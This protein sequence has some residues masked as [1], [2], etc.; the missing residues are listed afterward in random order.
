MMDKTIAK[1]LTL[2]RR[3]QS[4][5]EASATELPEDFVEWQRSCRRGMFNRIAEGKRPTRFSAHLPVVVT[6]KTEGDF[7]AH[8]ATKGTGFTP[9]DEYLD[10][11]IS[12]FDN[13]LTRC[14]GRPWRETLGERVAVA[15]EFYENSDHIDPR[16][17][18]LLEI[19]QG[20]TYRNLL[21]D[22]H[23][24]LHYTGEGPD[25]PSFQINGLAEIV[26]PEDKRFQFI[27]LARQLFEHDHF[28]IH[29]P[30]YPFGYVV[31]VKEAYDKSPFHGRAGMQINTSPRRVPSFGV[32]EI[33]IPVD[34]SRYAEYCMKIGLQL[35]DHFSATMTGIHVYA[36]RLHD[37]RF[38]QMEAGL[39]PQYQEPGELKRQR[40]IHDSLITQGLELISD[41]YLNVLAER[42]QSAQIDFIGKR[43]EGKN[44]AALISEIN[45]GDYDLVLLGARGLGETHSMEWAPPPLGSVTERVARRSNADLLVVKNASPIGGKIVVAVDGSS[46]SFAGIRLALVLA[47]ATGATVEA[48]AAY[49]PHF[50]TVA[51][52]EL[53]GVLSPE[54]GRI[55]RFKEQE[56][57]H[58]EIID[59][60]IAKI[61]SDHLETAVRIAEET[62]AEIETTLLEGKPYPAILTYLEDT[63]PSL[64][65][66]GRLGV[67][68]DEHLDLGATAENLLRLAPCHVLLVARKFDPNMTE[69]PLEALT[70]EIPWTTE[71]LKRLENIPPFAR[72]FARKAIDDFARKND[73]PEVTPDVMAVAREELGM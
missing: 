49:D 14:Q 48:V 51:F 63:Q 59:Q 67:H 5:F 62:G 31:W 53:E 37:D 39:P 57:L 54:A 7:L 45:A 28:H 17:L 25:Y 43:P 34:N 35:A 30:D 56:K 16:R 20:Q 2:D 70:E 15:R 13:C 4:G 24:T 6:L 72:S 10:D 32:K 60:G 36:A 55:F 18:G 69:R 61:Y 50:H 8:S 3:S 52:R 68:A 44:Y 73:H 21:A 26:G 19:F 46:Q 9:R 38:K 47:E 66:V 42:C 33:L 22:P 12:R 11:Y 40:R 65:V 23:L 1:E 71:A 64:L 41:S 29:Q 58:N 27:Y